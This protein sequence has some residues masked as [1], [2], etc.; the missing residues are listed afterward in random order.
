MTYSF[1]HSKVV[2]GAAPSSRV[3]PSL[4]PGDL[5]VVGLLQPIGDG[6]RQISS[7]PSAV[8]AGDVELVGRLERR[9]DLVEGFGR[10]LWGL[11]RPDAVSYTHLD[12]YKRQPDSTTVFH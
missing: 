6:V 11:H 9:G 1:V 7:L 12:V 4:G 8:L 10:G 5:V 2:D 3:T